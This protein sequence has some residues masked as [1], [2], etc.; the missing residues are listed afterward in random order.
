MRLMLTKQAD[1]QASPCQ[2][3]SSV[4]G[5]KNRVSEQSC[6]DD[7]VLGCVMNEQVDMH[8]H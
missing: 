4:S 5:G 2:A 7:I 1:T 6:G 3:E 8:G